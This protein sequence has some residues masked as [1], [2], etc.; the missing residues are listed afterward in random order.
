MTLG[1]AVT[2]P[3][4]TGF[5]VNPRP[6]FDRSELTGFRTVRL[7]NPADINPFGDPIKRPDLKD[8]DYY[9][10]LDD[11]ALKI[12]AGPYSYGKRPL[13]AKTVYV[14]E[15][16]DDWVK[17]KISLEVGYNDERMDVLIFRPR[18]ISS[19]IPAVINFPG[20]NLF[21]F[22]PDIDDINPGDMGY[23]FIVKSGRALIWPAYK[24]STNRLLEPG[25]ATPSTEDQRRA[26]RD[27]MVKWRIDTGRVL[28]YLEERADFD[29]D[30]VNYLGLSY[31]ALYMPIVLLFEDRFNAAVF[32]SGG[33]DPFTPPLSDGIAFRHRVKTP[34]LMLNGGQDYLIPE[35]SQRAALEAFG[36]APEDKRHVVFQAGHWPLPR[37]QMVNEVL[38][39]LDKY[40]K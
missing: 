18:N 16:H 35:S 32:L 29:S 1:G 27:M 39:W 34:V 23:D 13:N 9:K 20:L 19:R 10:P 30:N 22:P 31:G 8:L 24:G 36:A 11:A 12:Y 14:D 3:E 15:S 17:E 38:G 37:N 25:V 33:I 5:Q 21:T 7:L 26:F 6:R 28:D 2:E 40:K 4:Y